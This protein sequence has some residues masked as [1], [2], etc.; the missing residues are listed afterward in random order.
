VLRR[1]LVKI[2][3][4][5]LG[6]DEAGR[7]RGLSEPAISRLVAQI[8]Q[9]TVLG[10]EIGIVLGGG[11]ILRGRDLAL[12]AVRREVRDRMGMLATVVNALAAADSLIHAG[13]PA[14]VLTATPMPGVAEQFR[15]EVARGHLEQ[16]RVVLLAGGT[17]HPYFTTDTAAALRALEIGADALLKATKVDGVYSSDPV[18]NEDAVRY[19]ALTYDQVLEQQL[20][21]MD[22]TAV[23]LCRENHL[24]IHVFDM[25][26]PGNLA[27]LIRGEQVGTRVSSEP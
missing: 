24:P 3:G 18:D 16:G 20:G 22:L 8:T 14:V 13:Q 6:E 1:V 15:M 5:A 4:E 7:A 11:N 17:G 10:A 21:V 26:V 23:T 19:D 25:R 2:S 27:R 9:A 12:P